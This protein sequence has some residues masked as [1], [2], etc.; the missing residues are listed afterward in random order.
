MR[1]FV[2][3]ELPEAHLDAAEA[4][5]ARL[6]PDLPHA[7]W[8]PRPNMHVTL[9]FIGYVEPGVVGDV[10]A[11]CRTVAAEH[12][13]A[14][15]RLG[16]LGAFPSARRARVVWLGIEDP[17]GLTPALAGSLGAGLEP[18]GIAAED[19]D[20][21]PHLTLARLKQPRRAELPDAPARAELPPFRLDEVVLFRSR[22][23]RSG[24]TY[25]VIDR[26]PLG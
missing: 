15:L 8:I 20:Y 13:P 6:R 25:E 23:Q 10:G 21:H 24:V 4:V 12:E 2:A 3:F 9:R 5:A 26:F 11:V 7:R 18:L 17:A 14:E 19:R 22:P 1:L 16:P